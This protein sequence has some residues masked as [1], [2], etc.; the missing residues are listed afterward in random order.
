MSAEIEIFLLILLNFPVIHRNF[1]FYLFSTIFR[2][3]LNIS[4]SFISTSK[5]LYN[6]THPYEYPPF[7]ALLLF[8]EW[9]RSGGPRQ[10]NIMSNDSSYSISSSHFSELIYR[11]DISA[12]E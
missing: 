8:D 6:A 4:M 11:S 7:T 1:A 5:S 10:K 3:A 9:P 2:Q 12:F